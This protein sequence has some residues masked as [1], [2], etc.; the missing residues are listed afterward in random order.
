MSTDIRSAVT[1]VKDA[2]DLADYVRSCGIDVQPNGTGKWKALCPFHADSRPSLIINDSFQNYKCWACGAFGDLLEF[3]MHQENM[4]FGDTLKKLAADKGI[5]LALAEQES[6]VDYAAL[7]NIMLETARFYLKEFNALPDDHKAKAEISHRGLT[8]NNSSK[9]G[10]HYGYSPAGNKL[11]E[12]LKGLGLSLDTAKEAG[13]VGHSD[14]GRWYDFFRSRLMFVFTDRNGKPVGFSSRKLFEDDNRGKYINSPEGPLFKKSRILYNHNAARKAAGKSKNVYVVEG[15]FDVASMRAAGLDETIAA[16]GTAFTREH[17]EECAR[18]VGPTGRVVF[19]FDGDEAGIKAAQKTFI[20]LPELHEQAYVV[21]FPEGQ[22]P[23]DYRQK[24]GDEGLYKYVTK[25]ARSI[26]EFM[27]LAAAKKYDMSSPIGR[28]QYV[29]EGAS[30]VKTIKNLTLREQCIRIL[31]LESFT[32]VDTVK[33][34]VSKAKPMVVKEESPPVQTS[35]RYEQED[36]T[37]DGENEEGEEGTPEVEPI[38][39]AE[40]FDRDDHFNIAA[41]FISLGIQNPKWRP[42]VVRSKVFMPSELHTFV[43]ELEALEG[44][45]RL[46]PELFTDAPLVELLMKDEYATFYKFMLK[47]EVLQH[48]IYLQSRLQE[49]ATKQKI[50]R[51]FIHAQ[52]ML[53][54]EGEQTWEYY[55]ALRAKVAPALGLPSEE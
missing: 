18:M 44:K 55:K 24:H 3:S 52:Q 36:T 31:S 49:I 45:E 34:A 32:A 41:R 54:D 11:V 43:E 39:Y 1:Q 6:T 42:G 20:N 19:C 7:Q 13:V 29:E 21:V 35:S 12:H 2:Y 48:F 9:E 38:N 30:I 25:P 26:V 23:C 22:D 37:T 51:R 33:E 10:L 16:S 14:N 5:K 28:S 4:S 47:E 15:Q 46:Y 17:G 50:D 53:S 40:L 8:W 27:I